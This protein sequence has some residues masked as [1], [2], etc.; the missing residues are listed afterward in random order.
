VDRCSELV[1]PGSDQDLPRV[2][3]GKGG[4]DR[5]QSVGSQVLANDGVA[6]PTKFQLESIGVGAFLAL[7]LFAGVLTAQQ[8]PRAA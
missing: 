2:P 3:L 4:G 5:T 6:A 1:V 7:I 8:Q